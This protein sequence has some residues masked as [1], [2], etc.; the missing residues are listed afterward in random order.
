[1]FLPLVAL[2]FEVGLSYA[3]CSIV[4]LWTASDDA[5]AGVHCFWFSLN[6]FNLVDL[7][8]ILPSLFVIFRLRSLVFGWRDHKW[9]LY[10]ARASTTTTLNAITAVWWKKLSVK[11]SNINTGGFFGFQI[12]SVNTFTKFTSTTLRFCS[13]FATQ[14]FGLADTYVVF[15]IAESHSLGNQI[16]I[17]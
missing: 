16:I 8:N 10:H 12:T 11:P 3:R 4:G 13:V 17:I 7:C 9:L 2:R 5:N 14:L 6:T 15:E 1:M